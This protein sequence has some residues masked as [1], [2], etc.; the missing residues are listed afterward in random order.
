MLAYVRRHLA[1]I[2]AGAVA[3]ILIAVGGAVWWSNK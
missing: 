3:F 1:P 2:A